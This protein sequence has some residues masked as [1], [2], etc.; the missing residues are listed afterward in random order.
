MKSVGHLEV[1]QE[2]SPVTR[3]IGPRT[4]RPGNVGQPVQKGLRSWRKKGALRTTHSPDC[5]PGLRLSPGRAPHSKCPKTH[6]FAN[7]ADT[8]QHGTVHGAWRPERLALAQRNMG[9]RLLHGMG[10][11]P[12]AGRGLTNGG[13]VRLQI[14][15]ELWGCGRRE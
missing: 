11:G 6:Q 12:S 9:R 10:A 5:L 4:R 2:T 14:V 8:Q 3:R 13:G 7:C 15:A 1:W